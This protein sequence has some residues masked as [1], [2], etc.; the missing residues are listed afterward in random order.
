MLDVFSI[1]KAQ[2]PFLKTALDLIMDDAHFTD[3][4]HHT[5]AHHS[6]DRIRRTR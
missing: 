5:R 6:E 4:L 2:I 1:A 3:S